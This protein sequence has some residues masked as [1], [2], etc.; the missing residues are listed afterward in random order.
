MGGGV[1]PHLL[2][3]DGVTVGSGGPCGCLLVVCEVCQ[4]WCGDGHPES[5]VEERKFSTGNR[6]LVVYFEKVKEE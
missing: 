1:G 3:I 4:W 2:F 5:S 6:R